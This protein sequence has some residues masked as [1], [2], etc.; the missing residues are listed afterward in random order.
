MAFSHGHIFRCMPYVVVHRYTIADG[1]VLANFKKWKVK[2]AR[3]YSY[4]VTADQA[5]HAGLYVVE[6][7]FGPTGAWEPPKRTAIQHM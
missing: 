5:F 1:T 6:G 7:S 4:K 3:L 2:Q